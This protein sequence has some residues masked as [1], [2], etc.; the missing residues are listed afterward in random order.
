M[1]AA[2]APAKIDEYA[3]EIFKAFGFKEPLPPE[4]VTLYSRVK[5]LS[6]IVTPRRLSCET[7]AIVAVMAVDQIK[8]K[9]A[10]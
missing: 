7:L 5:R 2:P 1:P 3:T 10:R 4:L 8:R 9:D 6:D